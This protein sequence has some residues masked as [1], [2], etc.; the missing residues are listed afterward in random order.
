MVLYLAHTV[1]SRLSPFVRQIDFALDW[2]NI[3]SGRA[4]YRQDDDSDCTYIVLSG[5]MRSVLT[6][7]DGKKELVG[8]YGKGDLV[9]IV[10]LLRVCKYSN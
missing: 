3:E 5:R 4:L 9:G 6:R 2:M 7:S 10:S 8:E 1:I